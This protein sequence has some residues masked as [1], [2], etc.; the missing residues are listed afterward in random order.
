MVIPNG[1][2][3]G[4]H[5]QPRTMLDFAFR[6]PYLRERKEGRKVIREGDRHMCAL[7]PIV[8]MKTDG[9]PPTR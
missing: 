9:L 1:D 6:L 8:V 4:L 5:D 2:R 7:L 3:K